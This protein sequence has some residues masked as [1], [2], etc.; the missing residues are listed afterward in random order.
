MA[1]APGTLAAMDR[2]SLDAFSARHAL[3]PP[4]VAAALRLTGAQPDVTQW[5]A[6][7]AQLSRAAGLGAL[8]AGALFFVAANWQHYGVFGRF[9]L[10]QAALLICIALAVWRAPPAP[11]GQAALLLA[12]LLTGG[13]LALFGQTYQTG[14]DV[15]ELFFAWALLALPFALAGG[16]GALW[17][18]WWSVLN[19]GFALLC[20]WLGPDH[21]FWRFVAGWNV[22]RSALLML[23]CLVDLLAAGAIVQLQRTRFAAAAPT[24]LARYLAALGFL[25]GTAAALTVV[26]RAWRGAEPE[27]GGPGGAALLLFAAVSAG[28]AIATWRRRRDVFPMAL[29]AASWI[30][31]STTWLANTMRFDD[32]GTFFVIALWLVAASTA[33]GMLLMHW[34]R[35]WR[36][37]APAT[38]GAAA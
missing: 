12:T 19:L 11:L 8:G 23:P 22:D 25:F 29:I 21:F 15:H 24:W 20:G 37:A 10:L 18:L 1:H 4:A 6:F 16:S 28:I 2:P 5:R 14:A 9:A 38:A 17:A 7:A 34:V 35:A 31:V 13:L 36:G 30:A 26:A 32:V 3:A 33:S 27:P